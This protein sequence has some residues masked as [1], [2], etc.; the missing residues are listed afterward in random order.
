MPLIILIIILTICPLAAFGQ[1]KNEPTKEEL[2]GLRKRVVYP[3]LVK[4]VPAVYPPKAA[5]ENRQGIV[6]LTV[7]IDETGKVMKVE[8]RKSL[9]PDLDEAARIAV[10]KFEFSPATI[11]GKAIAVKIPIA[12]PFKLSQKAITVAAP[13]DPNNPAAKPVVTASSNDDKKGP[14]APTQAAT[15][16]DSKNN[17]PST[18]SKTPTATTKNHLI[19]PSPPKLPPTSVADEQI[20]V[21][22]KNEKKVVT[23]YTLELTEIQ[24]IPGTQ[25][26]AVRGIQNMPGVARAPFNLGLLVV[27]GSAPRNTKVYFEGLELPG[28]FH[29]LGLSSVINTDMISKMDFYP[30]NFSARYGRATGG[31]ID[32]GSKTPKA[33]SLHGYIDIDLWDGSGFLTGPIGQGSWALSLRRSWIDGILVNLPDVAVSPV[34]Y[35]YQGILAYPLF[36]GKFKLIVIGSD[37]RLKV[38]D[39]EPLRFTSSFQKIIALWTKKDG[40]DKYRMS[41]GGGRSDTV[42][43]YNPENLD[44]VY[45]RIN[46]RNE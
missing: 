12:Y 21:T 28:L 41:I 14:P 37:D 39:T 3:K 35:D 2:A 6:Y 17:T 25:G 8:V 44:W 27:R 15:K 24:T 16:T 23:R 22:G 26:D 34:Y 20:T 11:D 29:F 13:A 33:K 36:G 40:K 38:D 10:L 5:A 30:G 1:K 7:S 19:Q 42:F 31:I 18:T 46:W 32:I 4:H 9:F 45:T 43:V